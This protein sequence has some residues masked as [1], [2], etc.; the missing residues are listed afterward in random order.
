[1][2][3]AHFAP[4]I[5][6]AER[7]WN[8]FMTDFPKTK[9]TGGGSDLAQTHQ[10]IC[11]DETS[12]FPKAFRRHIAAH[13]TR[14]PL[15]RTSRRIKAF[16]LRSEGYSG[17]SARRWIK[18]IDSN[19]HTDN[20]FSRAEKKR[21][22]AWGFMP[23]DVAAFGITEQNRDSFIS[24][25][26]YLYLHP[27]NGK[28]DKWIRDRI[29]VLNVF[30][31][32]K[33]RFE[34]HHF[35]IV[36]RAGEPFV[37]ALTDEARSVSSDI[38]GIRDF[39][40]MQGTMMVTSAAWS[41]TCCWY[42]NASHQNDEVFIDDTPVS[43]EEFS[44]WLDVLSRHYSLVVVDPHRDY[45]WAEFFAPQSEISVRVRMLNRTGDSPVVAQTL[46]QVSIH[47]DDEEIEDWSEDESSE[48][49]ALD[50]QEEAFAAGLSF[51]EDQ[52]EAVQSVEDGHFV[53]ESLCLSVE[54][55]K[56]VRS[57]ARR[58]KRH[59][60]RFYSSVDEDGVFAGIL[61][62]NAGSITYLDSLPGA[63][64]P[65]EGQIPYWTDI[66]STLSAMCRHIA[67]VEFLE[68]ELHI[69][70]SGFVVVGLRS[71]PPFNKTIPF[72]EPLNEFFRARADA[73]RAAF[74]DLSVRRKRFFH[75]LS[76]KIRRV[77]ASAVALRGLVP[78]QS[79]RWI[80]DVWCD[81]ISQNGL[82]FK[83][84]IWAYKHGFLSYRITQ[85]GITPD[86]WRKFIS[87]FE[88]RWLRHINTKYKYWLEDKITLKYIASDYGECFPAYYYYTSLKDGENRVIP[89]MDALEGYG[90]SY[91]EIL[92]LAKDMGTLALKPDEG[93][94]GE[95]FYRLSWDGKGFL[96]NGKHASEQDVLKVLENPSNQYLV[97][98]YIEMHPQLKAIYPEAVNTIRVTVFKRDGRTPKLGNAYMR[99]GSSKT[100]VVDNVAAGG[101]VAAVDI[102]TG[103]YGNAQI[104][105]GVNQ[106]NLIAC[107]V[108]PD[109]GVRIEGILPNWEYAKKT[110]LSIADAIPQLEYFGFDLA[111]T[112]DG[113]KI[114]E[115]NRFPD[116]P[117]IDKLTPQITE[118]L[119]YKLDC[120][121]RMYGYDKRPCR[122][123]LRLPQR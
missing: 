61:T 89:M 54:R 57:L 39:L 99:I 43:L 93:S 26:D 45:S 32:F 91:S 116:Y 107:P 47:S 79:T 56:L 58:K 5:I 14:G 115:I 96:L 81:L 55:E 119:L 86:N 73:K 20:G 59:V 123:L 113:I 62:N 9:V 108:H 68:F 77:F 118:Y 34:T 72:S 60:R 22:Y 95:G 15:R 65:C 94:H 117:R 112:P 90:A 122:E 6:F 69:D 105:D 13:S 85:Y 3:C 100:G 51:K 63:E 75:N 1:M 88:Y 16:L 33:N 78:Y 50:I 87:D 102:E 98:E 36:R 83:D 67:Q 74:N 111:I 30:K 66:S 31:G 18:R 8:D 27:M 104:L 109:T 4:G 114:P 53:S 38:R 92:R 21:A 11:S 42:I 121:K 35:H 110:I 40:R 29:S 10:D 17:R 7:N 120:K 70:E 28:Y 37:I 24:E 48:D 12:R 49:A 44:Y 2:P 64:S 97:T 101:I 106:G 71:L 19:I 52:S 84:K 82:T 80:R 76:L 23:S 46:L 41:K 25:R 103:Q